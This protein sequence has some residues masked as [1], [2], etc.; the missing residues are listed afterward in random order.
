M[1]GSEGVKFPVPVQA[2]VDFGDYL[3]SV[4]KQSAAQATGQ[5]QLYVSYNRHCLK[6]QLERS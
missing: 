2:T 5:T 1:L 6:R 3:R 4:Y